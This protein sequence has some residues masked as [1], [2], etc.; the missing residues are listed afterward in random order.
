MLYPLSY[1]GRPS[2]ATSGSRARLG[3]VSLDTDRSRSP[4]QWARLIAAIYGPTL[5]ASIGFGAI[6]PLIALQATA[7]GASVG[8]AAFIT[9]LTGLAMLLFDLPAGTVASRLGERNSIVIACL[10]DAAVLVAVYLANSLPVL[11]AAVF[12]HGMTGSI[13][14]LARQT[15]LAEAIPMRYRARAMSS[16]GGVFRIGYFVGPLVGAAILARS[17]IRDAFIFAAG[18]SLFAAAVTMVLPALPTDRRLLLDDRGQRPRTWA[19]LRRHRRSLLTIGVGCLALM[20]VRSSRQTIIPLW[21]DAHGMSPAEISLLFALSMGFDVLLFFP[22]GAI[23]DRFGRWWVCVPT[24][25][26]ISI[27]IGILPLATTPVAIAVV[28]SLL[29]IGNGVSSGI[30]LTLGADASPQFGRAQFLAGWRL[31][32]DA[33]QSLGPVIIAAVTALSSLGVAAVVIGLLGCVG[34]GWLARWVPRTT[35]QLLDLIPSEPDSLEG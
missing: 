12:V 19:V 26:V 27:G 31:L 33:G 35:Q 20:M 1:G 34:G 17:E 6:I 11:A 28:A 22:G 9:S 29:G 7:L 21:A 24:M 3:G 30:V 16:L 2:L 10:I 32:S 5:L 4:G 25:F 8:L 15:Y 14:A 23:M 13:F 18:T